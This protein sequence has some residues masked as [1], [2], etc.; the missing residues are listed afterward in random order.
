MNESAISQ[1]ESPASPLLGVKISVVQHQKQP[2]GLCSA[3][4]PRLWCGVWRLVDR[5]LGA[6]GLGQKPHQLLPHSFLV[7][8]ATRNTCTFSRPFFL[9]A[10]TGNPPEDKPALCIRFYTLHAARQGAAPDFY[11]LLLHGQAS[12]RLA[13]VDLATI[14]SSISACPSGVLAP[15]VT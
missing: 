2:Q 5:L 7:Q 9:H 14:G 13:T 8:Q 15:I 11:L 12:H 4:A 1:F 3:V 6:E 10:R